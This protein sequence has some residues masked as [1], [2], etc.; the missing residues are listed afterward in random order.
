MIEL[1][2]GREHGPFDSAADVALCLAFEKLGRDEVEILCDASP[3]ATLTA[4]PD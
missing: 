3:M 1:D 4:W 2:T